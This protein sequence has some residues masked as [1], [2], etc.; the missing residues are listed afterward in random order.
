MSTEQAIALQQPPIVMF[1]KPVWDNPISR[2]NEPFWI[3]ETIFG[4]VSIHQK[5]DGIWRLHGD[6][7]SRI[8]D[9]DEEYKGFGINK[10]D[11]S[12]VYDDQDP[13]VLKTVIDNLHS[14]QLEKFLDL[15]A[16]TPI[17]P[18]L[19]E[20][21]KKESGLVKFNCNLKYSSKDCDYNTNFNT[22]KNPPDQVVIDVIEHLGWMAA[23]DGDGKRAIAALYQ[24][25]ERGGARAIELAS[26]HSPLPEQPA[27]VAEAV[28]EN[29]CMIGQ[30][31]FMKG[32]PV[33]ALIEHAES[34]YKAEAVAQNSKIEFHKDCDDIWFAHEVP[35]FGTVQLQRFNENGLV[36]WDIHFNECWQGPFDNRA[37]AIQHLE[38]C[39]QEHRDEARESGH[40]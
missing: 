2:R 38:E 33:S 13:E 34:I 30:T 39:I 28:L 32:T 15:I 16:N 6:F 25:I 1:K 21:V 26:K 9:D 3:C 19:T 20:P 36:E 12:R 18:D 37:M 14:K 22:S 8:P 10:I 40:D 11:Q 31:W 4:I 27:I 35:F 23:L 24:G 7:I 29:D 5:T 17:T